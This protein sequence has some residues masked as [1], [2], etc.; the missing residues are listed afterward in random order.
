MPSP[1]IDTHESDPD[2]EITSL[3]NQTEGLDPSHRVDPTLTHPAG[4]ILGIQNVFVVI[5]QFLVSFL[6]S[7]VFWMV[8]IDGEEG[9]EGI[10]IVFW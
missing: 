7:F 10:T 4:T 1:P 2:E 6:A 8:E 5:P 9:P 3:L